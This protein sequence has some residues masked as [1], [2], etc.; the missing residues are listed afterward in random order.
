MS[1]FNLNHDSQHDSQHDSDA[2]LDY[3]L[4]LSSG[5]ATPSE[6]QT[7]ESQ[8]E[9]QPAR[10]GNWIF[11]IVS[12]MQQHAIIVLGYLHVRWTRF[13]VVMQQLAIGV[14]EHFRDQWTRFVIV[15]QPYAIDLLELLRD[16]RT[17]FTAI[18]FVFLAVCFALRAMGARIAV[19]DNDST[20]DMKYSYAVSWLRDLQF[21]LQLLIK[22][23]VE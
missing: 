3:V 15:M 19:A 17:R 21:F 23:V 9:H 14:R 13:V 10:D 4:Q 12:V 5:S 20:V 16:K 22:S 2:Q 6:V 8:A 1:E 7:S 11:L 18:V